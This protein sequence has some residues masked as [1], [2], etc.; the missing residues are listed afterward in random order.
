MN[1]VSTAVHN[2]SASRRRAAK[3]IGSLLVGAVVMIACGGSDDATS[4]TIADPQDTEAPEVTPVPATDD[5]VVTEPTATEPI[6]TEPVSTEV[7]GADPGPDLGRVV[8]LSEEYLLADVLALGVEPIASSVSVESEGIQGIPGY[9][10]SGIEVLPMTTLSLEYVAS[11][12]PDTIIALQF[13]VDQVGEDVLSGIGDLVIVPD[14]L[15]NREQMATLGELLGRESQATAVI[16]EFDAATEAASAAVG[17]DCVVSL[18]AIYSGP[19]VAAF[20]AGPWEIPSSILSTGCVLDPGPDVAE[21]DSNGRVWLSPEQLGIL[22]AP[23]I[24]LL[25]SDVVEGESDAVEEI[26]A[27]PLWTQLPAVQSDDVVVY[28]RLGY[29]GIEGQIRFLDEFGTQF[30]S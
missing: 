16:E 13:W 27:N 11:L 7:S 26:T 3:G 12:E 4:A 20:V 2:P 8:V 28:D 14:A 1:T 19:S 29:P 10:T 6:A 25:Q 23:T 24:M 30:A 5:P 17:D 21:P 9:D 15:G 22:D 18:A